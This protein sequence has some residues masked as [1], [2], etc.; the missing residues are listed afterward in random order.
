MTQLN[1]KAMRCLWIGGES[2]SVRGMLPDAKAIMKV[3]I[4]DLQ[5]CGTHRVR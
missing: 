3:Q 4:R 5:N 2:H 1:A